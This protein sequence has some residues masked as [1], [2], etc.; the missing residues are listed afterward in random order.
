MSSSTQTSSSST[1]LSSSPSTT[2]HTLA[3]CVTR[4][5]S[6][7]PAFTFTKSP[8]STPPRRLCNP[9]KITFHAGNI[10]VHRIPR[11]GASL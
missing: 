5:S 9:T 8:S 4:N 10:P 1:T 2:T 11:G 6:S 7:A 3:T